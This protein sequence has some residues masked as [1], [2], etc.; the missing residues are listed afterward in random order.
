[1]RPASPPH[2]KLVNSEEDFFHGVYQRDDLVVALKGATFPDYCICCN[3]PANG[4]LVSKTVFWHTPVLLPIL[5]LS[6]PFYLLMAT[7]FRRTLTY[8]IPLCSQHYFIRVALTTIGVLLLP[9]FPVLAFLAINGGEPHWVLT[10]ILAS[11]SGVAS[12]GI[13]RNP[14]WASN[15]NEHMAALRGADPAF[16]KALPDYNG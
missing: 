8:K 13:G 15:I 10:G 9:A 16:V 7:S 5:L 11:L 4:R 2:L 6:F 14:I 12:L 1:M 3:K